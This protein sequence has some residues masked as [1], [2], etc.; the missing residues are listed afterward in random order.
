MRPLL[1]SINHV[2]YKAVEANENNQTNKA[3]KNYQFA[4]RLI[5]DEDRVYLAHSTDIEEVTYNDG[6][7]AD[8]YRLEDGVM[9]SVREDEPLTEID[10]ENLYEEYTDYDEELGR[11]RLEFEDYR[12][13][14]RGFVKADW[15]NYDEQRY[16]HLESE[17]GI[18]TSCYDFRID[19][20]VIGGECFIADGRVEQ[21][22]PRTEAENAF[23]FRADDGRVFYIK[24]TSPFFA[25][26]QDYFCELIDKDEFETFEN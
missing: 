1:T 24:M 22:Y 16:I 7:Y 10:F 8:L 3:M 19:T 15:N 5:I 17:H 4:N 12:G 13:D 9:C 14:I 18:N 26:E 11:E 23:E 20:E 25:D 2:T 6:T 21:D